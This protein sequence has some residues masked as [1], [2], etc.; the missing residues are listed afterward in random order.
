MI[1]LFIFTVKKFIYKFYKLN[2]I[3]FK[4]NSLEKL[5]LI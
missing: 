5:A 2:G 1:D 3:N 4:L